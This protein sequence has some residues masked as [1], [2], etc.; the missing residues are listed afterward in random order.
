MWK[1]T[2]EILSRNQVATASAIYSCSPKKVP[3]LF[4]HTTDGIL[5]VGRFVCC[6]ARWWVADPASLL[7]APMMVGG[8]VR[9]SIFCSASTLESFKSLERIWANAAS[10]QDT[11]YCCAVH[12]LCARAQEGGYN[13][14]MHTGETD[15]SGWE[16]I[17]L[18]S[19]NMLRSGLRVIIVTTF[20]FRQ[21]SFFSPST[22]GLPALP[23]L[24]KLLSH[25]SRSRYWSR[26]Q[27]VRLVAYK[28]KRDDNEEWLRLSS[29][30][31]I[32]GNG[33]SNVVT[34]IKIY[35]K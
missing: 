11:C 2:D 1:R 8:R 29:V 24:E 5:H 26:C 35:S 31:G 34:S 14:C 15:D 28:G 6:L 3:I 12:V 33:W 7:L 20:F 30:E 23:G 19:S 21:C 27:N 13:I 16:K 10:Q 18:Q 9:F 17:T 25:Y 22:T 32:L 4:V